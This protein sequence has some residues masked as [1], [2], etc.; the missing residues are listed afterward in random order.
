[1]FQRPE[2]DKRIQ[3][4]KKY[5]RTAGIHVKSYNDLWAGCKSNAARVRCLKDLLEKNGINGRPTIEKCKK[6]K[7]KNE[8]LKDVAELNRGNII[9]EGLRFYRPHAMM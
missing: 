8:R 9:S 5:V 7:E 6:A 4:L 3:I 1:M 2:D